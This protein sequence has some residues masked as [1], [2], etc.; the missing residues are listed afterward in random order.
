MFPPQGAGPEHRIEVV[1]QRGDVRIEPR[2]MGNNILRQALARPRQ[3]VLLRGPHDDQLLAAPKQ[4]TQL[5]RLGVRQ[6]A[7]RWA[8]HVSKMRQRTGIQRSPY[9]PTG[10]W[11]AQNP[12][13]AAG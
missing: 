9:W 3:A 4:G 6:R 7:R 13:P 8:N 1:V 5:L 11:R 2:N 12:A 10:Q